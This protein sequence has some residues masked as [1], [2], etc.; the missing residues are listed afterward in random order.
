M[1]GWRKI[2]GVV[3]IE[4][5]MMMETVG[6]W[7]LKEFIRILK[8]WHVTATDEIVIHIQRGDGSEN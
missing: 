8:E 1:R 3:I 5:K 7:S 6:F 4:G 2:K